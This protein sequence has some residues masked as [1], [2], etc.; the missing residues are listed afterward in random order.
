[1]NKKWYCSCGATWCISCATAAE[2]A[3]LE[4][5]WKSAHSGPGHIPSNAN[6]CAQVRARSERK[7]SQYGTRGFGMHRRNPV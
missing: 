1:M 5:E 7:K 6:F 3:P 4:A 2:I